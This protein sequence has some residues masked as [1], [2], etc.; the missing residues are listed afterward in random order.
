M[1][2]LLRGQSEKVS[3]TEKLKTIKDGKPSDGAEVSISFEVPVIDSAMQA[4]LLDLSGYVYSQEG[5]QRYIACQL[6]NC[7]TDDELNIN[8]EVFSASELASIGDMTDRTTLGILAI[9]SREVDKTIFVQV[10]DE[11]KFG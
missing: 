4:R 11:K 10:S 8:G 3:V 7:I 1:I 9:I 5:K 6:K 2:K